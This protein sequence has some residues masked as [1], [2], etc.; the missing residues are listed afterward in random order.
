[1]TGLRRSADHA[2]VLPL[3][4]GLATAAAAASVAPV[5]AAIASVHRA[6]AATV[7]LDAA[8]LLFS[9]PRLNAAGWIL[10]GLALIGGS[11]IAVGLRASLR[12]HRAYRRFLASRS[13]VTWPSAPT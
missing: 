1:M 7:R 11:A 8:G 6:P 5:G 13:S 12:Q 4:L 3:A 10:L 9:Y 2:V